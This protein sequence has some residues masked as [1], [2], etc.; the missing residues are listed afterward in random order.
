MASNQE[1]EWLD[2]K[3]VGELVERTPA[4]VH[5]WERCQWLPPAGRRLGIRGRWCAR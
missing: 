5:R 2:A 4:T 1:T 3:G